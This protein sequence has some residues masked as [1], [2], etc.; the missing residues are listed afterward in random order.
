MAKMPP[1]S[2][3][4]RS[5]EVKPPS[6][7][8]EAVVLLRAVSVIAFG[9]LAVIALRWDGG[10]GG[11]RE[12]Q[13]FQ[14][15]FAGVE[16]ELQRAYRE[17][18][19]GLIEAENARSQTKT[20]PA[21]EALAAQGVPPFAADPTRKA[22]YAWTLERDGL[23]VSYLGVPEGSAPELLAWIQEPV[24]GYGETLRPGTPADETHHVLADGSV[25]HVSVW[26]RPR[27]E[28]GGAP[29]ERRVTQP[30]EAGFLQILVGDQGR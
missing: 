27:G 24:P 25:L 1:M 20:W 6:R 29:P 8:G 28:A 14:R 13:P 2:G 18:Q 3:S 26:Y 4:I 16:P 10:P 22:R 30:V 19:E 17:L 15:L 7:S 23:N 9:A 5:V 21:P 12:L 11:A